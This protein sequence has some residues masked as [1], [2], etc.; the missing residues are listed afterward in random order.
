MSVH[1]GE[2]D[3]TGSTDATHQAGVYS[4]KRAP[5]AEDHHTTWLGSAPGQTPTISQSETDQG[6]IT[7]LN[8]LLR[9][10]RRRSLLTQEELA[11]RVGVS[12]LTVRRWEQ[13]QRPQPHSLRE[14]RTVLGAS[15]AELGFLL[16]LDLAGCRLDRGG[17]VPRAIESLGLDSDDEPDL[18]DLDDA[19]LR[20]RRSYS[21][22]PPD[23]L[24]HR[25]DDRLRQVR[26]LLS[27]DHAEWRSDLLRAASWLALLRATVLVDLRH[28]EAAETGVRA[29]RELA[30]ESGDREAE[31]WTWETAAWIAATGGRQVAARD[32]AGAGIGVAPQ[33]SHA[34][35]AVTLQRARI[36]GALGDEAAAVRDLLAGERALA[37]AGPVPHVD[38]HY[39]IDPAKAAFFASGAMA[40]LHRP[41]ETIEHAAEVVRVSE[42]TRSRNYWPM[43]V[44]NARIEWAIALVDLGEED[45]AAAQA[46]EALDP[47]WFRPDTERRMGRLLARMRDPVLRAELT[48]LLRDRLGGFPGAS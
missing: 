30:Q 46:R 18:A 29:A 1:R 6:A 7:Q 14:L 37:A 27:G 26:R 16:D 41:A 42:D 48:A 11:S 31:A 17:P 21:T 45:E 39:T 4:P 8:H 2:P 40:S 9:E 15:P 44:A 36:S 20:L 32:L 43:R 5:H 25:V 35:V 24:R 38:D 12:V 23:E 3:G 10:A 47:A 13:G 22:T 28:F 34:L 19:V 33:G